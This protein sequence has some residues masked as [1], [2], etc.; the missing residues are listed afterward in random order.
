MALQSQEPRVIRP[1][2]QSG[3]GGVSTKLFVGIGL[4][5]V[6][7]IA[8]LAV[9]RL[10]F[11]GGQPQ[12]AAALTNQPAQTPAVK[13]NDPACATATPTTTDRPAQM[14]MGEQGG[15]NTLVPAPSAPGSSP[16]PTPS[17]SNPA[18]TTPG[19]TT[20]GS[21]N[22]TAPPNPATENP[23]NPNAP[24]APAPGSA[25]QPAA[26]QPMAPGTTTGPASDN[27][28]PSETRDLVEAA[29][30]AMAG[31]KPVEARTLLNQALFDKRLPAE[32][33]RALRSQI[34]TINDQLI[35][36]TAVAAGDPLTDTYTIQAGDSLVTLTRKQGLPVDW[37]FI[38]RINKITRPEALR[39]GQ[40]IKVVRAPFHA[41]VHKNEYRM[42]LYMGD[43]PSAGAP[44][45]PDGQDA[46]WTY[47]RS[48]PVG[49]G[50]SNGTPEGRF[51]VRPKSKLVNPRW[52]NPRTGEVF[53][54]DNPKNP[55]GE[56]W[57][58]LDGT[59]DATRKFTGYGVHGTIDP[60]SVGK[61]MSMGCVRM[62]S[63]DIAVIYEILTERIST[64]TIIK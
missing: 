21:P 27:V 22:P 18:P 31:N 43:P 11:G 47:I 1:S 63:D 14:V 40:K 25:P 36:G 4:V 64:V 28:V 9:W 52:V 58:G 37:R 3:A 39:V 50:E 15:G 51:V 19:S 29:N 30:R 55:I 5:A 46:S 12:T 26:G 24:A 41:I 16:M 2:A 20:G 56:H 34:A 57:L 6:V 62:L 33:R 61:Q 60:S 53:E 32:E 49:L 59:D 42:D 45:G 13:I 48:F 10:G 54:A 38:Q 7:S 35:F 8:A 17:G 23:T 44:T